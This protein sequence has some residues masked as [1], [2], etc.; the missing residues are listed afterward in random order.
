MAEI[1]TLE[2][3][4][5]LIT[6][7]L[8]QIGTE[9]EIVQARIW[10]ESLGHRDRICFVPGNHDTYAR[11]SWPNLLREWRTYLP[12]SPEEYPTVDRQDDVVVIGLTS[13]VPTRPLSACGLL[14]ERQLTALGSMLEEHARAFSVLLIHHPP[15]PGMISY[16]KRLRD[17]HAL[18][19]VL[20]DH[21]ANLILHGHR[22][23]NQASERLGI[24]VFCTAPA[25]AEAAGFRVFDLTRE[26]GNWRVESSL[27][28]RAPS[29][30]ESVGETSWSVSVPG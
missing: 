1:E 2:P 8:T 15:L 21:P 13:A 28:T 19:Q 4:R 7:D 27:R 23:R 22:H 3:D 5:L 24:P 16:R 25:S 30:F 11:E 9:E 6:G 20:N 29:G 17:A 12:G 10:L 18:E 14:G 26:H